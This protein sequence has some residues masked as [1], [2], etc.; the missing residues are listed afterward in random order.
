MGDISV[1][2]HIKSFESVACNDRCRDVVDD[3]GY[4]DNDNQRWA[5]VF[6]DSKLEDTLADVFFSYKMTKVNNITL[7]GL[8]LNIA[9]YNAGGSGYRK[10]DNAS[11]VPSPTIP[12]WKQIEGFWEDWNSTDP[13]STSWNWSADKR[14]RS[15]LLKAQERNADTFELF[16][17]SPMWWMLYNHNPSG[18]ASGSTDNLQKWNYDKHALYLAAVASHARDKWGVSFGS[19]DAF[20]EPSSGWWKAS[21]GQE[22]CHFGADTQSIVARMLREELDKQDLKGIRVSASDENS[23]TLALKTWKSFSKDTKAAVAQVNV[24]GYEQAGGRRD[25]LFSAVDGKKL[26]NS[27]Y[28]DGSASGLDLASNL[29]LDFRWLHNTAYVYWQMIDEASG[30]GMLQGNME[31]ASIEKIN[32]KH[33]VFAHYTR[34]ILPGFKIIDGGDDNTIAA[35]DGKT[36]KL[37]LVLLNKNSSE[38]KVTIDLSKF[39]STAGPCARWRTSATTPSHSDKYVRDEG[40]CSI[41]PK[42]TL[43][44]LLTPESIVTLEIHAHSLPLD[45]PLRRTSG[46]QLC[47]AVD[48]AVVYVYIT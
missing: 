29:N 36:N 1:L 48:T 2:E 42:R 40:G 33:Y 22:G 24:H 35:Y 16:S 9:R 31:Q 4:D 7:P 11:M 3:D 25:L 14:Q 46:Q 45:Q 37:V 38:R 8:G 30:W 43:E 10:Y 39:S 13:S 27:E 12:K 44:Q 32:N 23:Y 17:N 19:V 41:T 26:W 21:N 47:K 6:G 28:G 18:S 20:N 5:N 15:M 34:H